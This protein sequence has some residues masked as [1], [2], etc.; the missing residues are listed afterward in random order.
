MQVEIVRDPR[1]EASQFCL[2]IGEDHEVFRDAG[3]EWLRWCKRVSDNPRLMVYRHKLTGRFVL[4]AWAWSPDETDRPV[5]QE[6]EGFT[7]DPGRLWPKDL[8]NPWVM[9]ARLQ[10]AQDEAGRIRRQIQDR[11]AAKKRAR[12]LDGMQRKDSVKYLRRRGFDKQAFDMERGA[13]P[14]VGVGSSPD[15]NKGWI[16]ALKQMRKNS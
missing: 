13:T 1:E 7:E 5:C 15:Q 6:L 12:E 14:F 10:P 2:A 9:K 11:E 3:W 8:L 16:E 4:G